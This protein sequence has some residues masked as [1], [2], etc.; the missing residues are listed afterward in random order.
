[1]LDPIKLAD[2]L[3]VAGEA[4]KRD[5]A[6]RHR[7]RVMQSKWILTDNPAWNMRE[8]EYSPVPAPEPQLRA[9]AERIDPKHEAP[10]WAEQPQN[11]VN[12]GTADGTR[13]GVSPRS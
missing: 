11:G 5:G 4:F 8:I 2:E 10:A 1:M 7:N 6:V 13:Q 12:D 3:R 9:E